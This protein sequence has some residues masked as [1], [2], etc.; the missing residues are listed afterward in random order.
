M[1]ISFENAQY[2]DV[3]FSQGESFDVGFTG[4]GAQEQ[5]GFNQNNMAFD[6]AF[7]DSQHFDVDFGGTAQVNPYQGSYEVTPKV[8][9]QTLPTKE[10]YL[11]KD[12]TVYGVP[13]YDT[14]NEYGTTVYIA[15][16]AN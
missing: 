8:A 4:G 2:I 6:V 10:R 12:V 1:I 13:R 14:S 5:V 11:S 9:Q 7:S 16:E 3:E 15:S